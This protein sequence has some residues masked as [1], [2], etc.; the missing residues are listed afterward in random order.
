MSELVLYTNPDE[1]ESLHERAATHYLDILDEN[2]CRRVTMGQVWD[3]LARDHPD[4]YPASAKDGVLAR[5]QSKSFN[6]YLA[7]RR[8][9]HIT[10]SIA[11]RLL[12]AELGAAVGARS[13]EA[14]LD[15]LAHDPDSVKASEKIAAAKLGFELSEK[16]ERTLDSLMDDQ[17]PAHVKNAFVQIIQGVDPDRAQLMM[18][19]YTRRLMAKERGEVVD[20]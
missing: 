3:R 6:E 5:L 1:A 4:L 13:L 8:R 16:V 19:E 7:T 12:A 14:Y 10:H 17:Q 11:A 18:Q 9:E 2:P 20:A 15:Q